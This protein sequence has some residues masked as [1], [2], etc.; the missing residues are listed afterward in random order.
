MSA[1]DRQAQDAEARREWVRA[2]LREDPQTPLQKLQKELFENRATAAERE[3]VL[4]RTMHGHLCASLSHLSQAAEFAS[5]VKPDLIA[6]IRA[7]AM[8]LAALL[9]DY[10]EFDE[11][12]KKPRRAEG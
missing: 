9:P 4:F 5:V 1:Q 2:I 3:R 12:T 10:A 6:T 11:K 8:K 7:Q